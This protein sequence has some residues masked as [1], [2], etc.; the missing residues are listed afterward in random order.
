M[1]IKLGWCEDMAIG[2]LIKTAVPENVMNLLDRITRDEQ[3]DRFYLVGGTSL[4]LRIGHRMSVD[5][6]LFTHEDFNTHLIGETLTHQYAAESLEKEK[7]TVRA[8]IHDVKVDLIAHKYPLIEPIEIIGN[9]R[10]MGLKDIAAM[11][12]N[13]ISNRGA[14]KDFWDYAALL[15]HFTTAEMLSFFEK[16]YPAANAWHAEKSLS[17]F[18]D[19]DKDPDPKDL[20]GQTWKEIKRRILLSLKI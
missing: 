5:I 10:I 18:D 6:D 17:F 8:V 7:N 14:K 4:A 12:I 13:A 20:S 11:K 2:G 9:I 1:Q 15:D 19:S 16:K 3:F